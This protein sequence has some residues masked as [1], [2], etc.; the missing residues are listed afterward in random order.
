MSKHYDRR[1]VL[2]GV[3][4]AGASLLLPKRGVSQAEARAPDAGL[5]ACPVLASWD[6]DA[7]GVGAVEWEQ[8]EA[9]IQVASVSAHTLRL[10]VLPIKDGQ[11]ATV[12]ANGSLIRT[13]WGEPLLKLR[14]SE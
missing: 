2:K 10:T 9:E 6:G 4:A 11:I 1:Q 8:P 13:T 7:P 14:G 12:P 5:P 3:A